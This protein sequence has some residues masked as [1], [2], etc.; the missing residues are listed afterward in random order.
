MDNDCKGDRVCEQG[1]C[2][3]PPAP[4]ALPPAPAAPAGAAPAAAGAPAPLAAAPP[5]A[6]VD[7]PPPPPTMVR[8]S[9]GMMA[10]GIVMVSLT[11]VALLVALGASVS[12]SVCKVDNGGYYDS[13]GTYTGYRR[14][15]NNDGLIYGSLLTAA[16]LVGV[17]IPLIVIGAKK[18][19]EGSAIIAP[20]ATPTAAGI[21][22]H[23]NL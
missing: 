14:D 17:G 21:G 2:V 11:P 12:Q 22:L 19:P 4:A 6:P 23:I 9:S 8:H 1:Q 5:P 16:A 3:A 10:G 18:E 7:A 13:S 20:W 15:C